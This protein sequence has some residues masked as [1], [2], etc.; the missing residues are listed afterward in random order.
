LQDRKDKSIATEIENASSNYVKLYWMG[1][2]GE[3][4]EEEEKN[5]G[6]EENEEKVKGK[7][8]R[9]E[10]E[11]RKGK[12]NDSKDDDTSNINDL[13]ERLRGLERQKGV[14]RLREKL[15][16]VAK[17]KMG[18]YYNMLLQTVFICLIICFLFCYCL[19]TGRTQSR[20]I[21]TANHCQENCRKNG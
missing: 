20:D 6:K 4:S 16:D 11:K 15:D 17:Q 21:I 3:K 12:E 1:R 2:R 5:Q 14:K 18:T 7:G 9:T 10:T 13:V 19:K 8:K